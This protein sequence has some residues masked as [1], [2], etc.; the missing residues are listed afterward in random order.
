MN[1]RG[2]GTAGIAPLWYEPTGEAG[3]Q[4]TGISG[5]GPHENYWDRNSASILSE[6]IKTR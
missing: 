2:K 1:S 3:I 6:D 5:R 4:H